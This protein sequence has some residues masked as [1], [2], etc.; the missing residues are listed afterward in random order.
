MARPRLM[1]DD[2]TM[3]AGWATRIGLMAI[4]GRTKG[5]TLGTDAG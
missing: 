3:P 4:V 5:L 1:L 2:G